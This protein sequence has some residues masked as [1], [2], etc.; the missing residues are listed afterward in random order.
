MHWGGGREE[1]EMLAMTMALRTMHS[2]TIVEDD[3]RS[4]PLSC[5][6]SNESH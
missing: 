1:G 4:H 6:H 2:A 3:L 5:T